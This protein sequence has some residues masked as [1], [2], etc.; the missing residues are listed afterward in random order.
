MRQQAPWSLRGTL[1]VRIALSLL[2]CRFVFFLLGLWVL[3]LVRLTG[4]VRL[5][6]GACG[7]ETCGE[8]HDVHPL[9]CRGE[10]HIPTVRSMARSTYG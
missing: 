5:D 3:R 4:L 6:R 8:C 9:N 1:L 2:A 7:G 10:C